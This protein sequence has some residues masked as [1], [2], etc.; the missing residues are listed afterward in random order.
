[1]SPTT[2]RPPALSLVLL[3]LGPTL[4]VSTT[5][6]LL[7]SD[8]RAAE[9][10]GQLN[11]TVL[12]TDG[13]PVPGVVLTMTSPSLQGERA[14]E[15]NDDGAFVALALPPGEY[16]IEAS[17]PGFNTAAVNVRVFTGRSTGITVTMSLAVAG[18]E[19][20]IVDQKP[21]VDVTATRTGVVL[22][23]EMMR[24]IPNPGRDYQGAT[25]LSPGVVGGGNPNMRGGTFT[26]NQFYIDGV[27]TTDPLTGTFSSNLNFDAI[28][29]LQVITGGMDAEYGR[30]LGGAVNIVTRSGSNEFEGD[31]QLLYSSKA[32][33]LYVPLPDEGDTDDIEYFDLSTAVNVG[34]PILK[35][36]LWFFGSFQ[37]NRSVYEETVPEEVGRDEPMAPRYWNSQYIYGKLTW[38]P[39]ADH[40]IWGL[41]SADPTS[42]ENS[43]QDIYTLSSGEEWWKQGGWLSSAG[44]LWSVSNRSF[45]Q[46]EV[47]TQR[48]YI[49]TVPI[50][51]LWCKRGQ[52]EDCD[53]ADNYGYSEPG[54]F[55]NT[56]FGYGPEPYGSESYRNRHSL[57]SAFTQLFTALGTHQA[58]TGINV[59]LMQSYSAFPGVGAETEEEAALAPDTSGYAYYEPTGD[60]NDIESYVP[61]TLYVYN[62]QYESHISGVLFAWYLQDVWQPVPRLTLR[63]GMRLDM[64]S[65]H[66]RPF[67][68]PEFGDKKVFS[69][70][71]L[72]PRMGLAYDLTGD[73]RTSARLFYG[74][75]YDP[76]YLAVADTLADTDTG[77]TT[78]S[79]DAERDE[80][81]DSGAS[82]A[83]YFL[84]HEDLRTPRSDEINVGISRDVGDGWG[85]DLGFTYEETR[86]Q[87]EDDEV[88]Q[89]W[90]E[91]GTDVIGGRNGTT[92]AVYRLRTPNEVNNR[93]T[94]LELQANRQFDENW[95]MIASYTWSRTYG[96]LQENTTAL[97]SGS[98][99]NYT[100]NGFDVG[101]Q[102]YD[103]P[104]NLKVAGSY[105]DNDAL[106]ISDGTALGFL[107]G[108]NFNTQSGD[109]YRKL[110][111]NNYYGSWS[112]AEDPLDGTYR[113]PMY[114]R[115]DLKAGLTLSAGRTTWD[116]TAECF[117][118]FNDR[119]V[120]SVDTRYGDTD[121]EGVYVDGNGDPY[122]GR[123]TARQS[124]RYFQFGL[125]G[126]FN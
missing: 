14:V 79:W 81:V 39:H 67:L 28:E 49:V 2:P 76:G 26:S 96:F 6:A 126:E 42:I 52:W 105:R 27:N 89:I 30:A 91:D 75:F 38:S 5:L 3:L 24:D 118:V 62:S 45:L 71:N 18:E 99:D 12:D 65:L 37:L 98:F 40:R 36:R 61:D 33:R 120:V 115:L 16:R 90:N 48:S 92:S 13:L 93:F 106:P 68:D 100:Q 55:S 103:I 112:N 20:V 35:D 23:K 97:A 25:Q 53:P 114:T 107:T 104:H 116:L 110:Y 4:A 22:T 57:N 95:G 7:S 66:T 34:G 29:E 43:T 58:K 9:L 109:I 84:V 70:A 94:S 54:W 60:P 50:Q 31:V 82:G 85:L 125:R 122:W 87:W 102:P 117:N 19:M 69:T 77:Y 121:G 86:N 108:W 123:P 41:F 32:T 47:F 83:G 124:P 113:M 1:M 88:N 11:G 15:T 10:T 59:E 78:Y 44:H 8:A 80:W 73:G 17:K 21:A 63:P 64:S 119:T 46:T 72:A 74:R 101:L 56:G 51:E 111:Y